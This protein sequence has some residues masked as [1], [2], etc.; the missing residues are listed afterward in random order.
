[1]KR[2]R[3]IVAS[4]G[5]LAV[6]LVFLGLRLMAGD[7]SPTHAGLL[8]STSLPAVATTPPSKPLPKGQPE[9]RA[10]PPVSF[11]QVVSL[12]NDGNATVVLSCGEHSSLS[13]APGASA[14]FSVNEEVP[15][16]VRDAHGQRCLWTGP[17]TPVGLGGLQPDG[18]Q[19]IRTSQAGSC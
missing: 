15:V 2:Q 14:R 18:S 3:L 17:R 19:V 8:C 6:L 16:L 12:S 4:V 13:F 11:V 5:L 1:M 7:K 9:L 10:G